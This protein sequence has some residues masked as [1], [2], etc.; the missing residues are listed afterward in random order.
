MEAHSGS[1]RLALRDS[2]VTLPRRRVRAAHSGKANLLASV[3]ALVPAL[4]AAAV[5]AT[6]ASAHPIYYPYRPGTK[7]IDPNTPLVH[8]G[9]YRPPYVA[10]RNTVTGTWADV[11]STLP[12]ASGPWGPMQLTDGTV[13]FQDYCTSNWWRLTPDSHGNYTDGAWSSV[14]A[15]P[16]GYAPLFFSEQVLPNGNAIVSGGEYNASGGSCATAYTNKSAILDPTPAPAWT[17]VTPPSGWTSIGDAQSIILPNGDYMLAN[18]CD[19]PAEQAIGSITGTSVTWTTASGYTCPTG[20][21]C[22]DEQGYTA[23]QGGGVLMVDVWNHGSNYDDYEIYSGG[24]W[25]LAGHTADYLSNTSN[26]ELGPAA[27]T[28]RYGSHGTVIQFG[29][30]TTSGFNDVYNVSA[31][32]WSAGP[33]MHVGNVIYDCADAPAATLPDGKILVQA[34]PG[35]FS[36]PSH[37][38]EFGINASGAV[39]AAQVN[40]PTTA[41]TTSSFESNMLVLPTGQV[42]WDNSQ[43][44]TN[45]VAIYT[46]VGNPRAA[47][48]PV[49]SSV[50]TTL[51]VGSTMNAISG[52][53]FNGF[54][55]GGVY[56]DDAQAATN[57]PLVRI[58]NSSSGQVCFGRSYNFSTMGVW[59]SGTTNALFDIPSSC[60]TGASKLQVVVNGIASPTLNVI[61]H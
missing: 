52:T 12:F 21:P 60:T 27:L 41:P 1:K 19:S 17:S 56:G 5:L 43:N 40:D 57:F 16:S 9:T 35:T 2:G 37:F 50:A 15:M 54:D 25:S 29:A 8:I 18:C 39:H 58:T 20:H 48:R 26:F 53:N 42:L 36:T 30:N 61:L 28:P 32:S 24:S 13:L 59:T 34:S 47:W 3:C 6:A 46:P 33:I 55:L 45:E 23:L 49:V 10:P 14:A 4:A 44:T 11:T 38:W 51:A 7:P 22:N 31:N